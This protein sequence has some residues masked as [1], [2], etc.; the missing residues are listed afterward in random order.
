MITMF[1]FVLCADDFAMTAGISHGILELLSRGRL[2]ATGAMTNRPHWP[3]FAGALADFDGHADLGVHLNLTCG[4]PL[5]SMPQFAA[6]GTLPSLPS[7]LAMAMTRRLPAA[8][9]ANEI[10]TQLDAF[11]LVLGRAPDFIDGHQHV[12]GIRGISRIFI[13]V[14]RRRY[15]ANGRRP[16][17]RVSADKVSRILRRRQFISKA[18]Q[19]RQLSSGF[20][21]ALQEAGF[22]TNDGFSGFSD[23]RDGGGYGDQ[24]ESYLRAPGSR[25]LVMC[26]PGWVDEELPTIDPVIGSREQEL[27]FF[28]SSYFT[29]MLAERGAELR[30][31]GA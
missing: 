28:A 21:K 23:F 24:F 14:L 17:I 9:I 6:N 2:S 25:Q 13:D 3:E 4:R 16:Y 15:P 8:E 22:K 7:I 26:H 18:L 5:R 12:H 19:V 11:E 30:R 20:G 31:F 10:N 29:D 27:E 1:G